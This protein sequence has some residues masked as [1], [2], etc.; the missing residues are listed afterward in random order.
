MKKLSLTLLFLFTLGCESF[1]E[2]ATSPISYVNDDDINNASNIPFLINGVLNNYSRAHSYVSLWADLLSDAIVNDG[3][4]Q[5]S[6]DARGEYLDN[7]IYDPTAGTYSPPYEA[8]AQTW[9]SAKT[10]KE[11]LDIIDAEE[12]VE[13]SGYYTAYLYQALP[14]YL[15]GTY[16]GRG[17]SYPSDGGATLDGSAFQSSS[18]LISMAT[19]YFDSALVY[20]TDQEA[21]IINSLLA[22]QNLYN[23]NFTE[24]ANY[25]V[26]GLQTGD[27]SFNVYPGLEDPW[28][29]W[30][31]FEAG[32]NR[33]RY[34]L[35]SRFKHLLG[36]DFEDTN[37]NSVWD[38]SEVFTDCALVG[39]DIGQGDGVYNAPTESEESIR[40]SMSVAGMT[41]GQSYSRYFQT[42]YP[43]ADSP[44]SIINW[45]ETYL[46][47]A[48]L[49]LRGE[50]VNMSALD[51]VNTVRNFYGLQSIENIDFSIL[52]H[53][54]DKELF[55]QGQRLVDQNRF[56]DLISWHISGEN[57]WHYL[58]V[59]YEE[60]LS[61]PN[62]P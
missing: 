42:K 44:I 58:P 43:E 60:E 11:K 12:S 24:A 59:P 7:G 48:E 4:V 56:S 54:R 20:A 29:N 52:L 9:R 31:W 19:T 26:L 38:T 17:P 13:K 14:C 55:C 49:A 30:Y 41:P 61:N 8:I 16:Y 22:R 57:T 35:A 36:E 18:S 53:E 46:I 15:L 37:N 33:T 1:V 32:N 27:A 51:A 28:P 10:L 45:Q 39:A 21:K 40:L 62:Y 6:T 2:N 23:G 47:L 5:G 34:T 3:K 25:A 50:T